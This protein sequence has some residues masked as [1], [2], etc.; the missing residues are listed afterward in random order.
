MQCR[1]QEYRTFI[2]YNPFSADGEEHPAKTIERQ[3]RTATDRDNA[4]AKI[5]W[6]NLLPPGSFIMTIRGVN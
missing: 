6:S 2:K 3:T 1:V 4:I 5:I